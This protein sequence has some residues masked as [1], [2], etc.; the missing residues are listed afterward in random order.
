MLCNEVSKP[1]P[2]KVFSLAKL[3]RLDIE[4]KPSYPYP[5]SELYRA[6][7]DPIFLLIMDKELICKDT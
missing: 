6:H 1:L 2:V 3:L 7:M 4:N 5:S